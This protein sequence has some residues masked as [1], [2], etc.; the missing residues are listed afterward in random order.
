MGWF[1]PLLGLAGR[2]AATATAGAA[3][4][5]GGAA[6][7]RSG[8]VAAARAN[9]PRLLGSAVAEGAEGAAARRF[10]GDALASLAE[11]RTAALASGR[12]RGAANAPGAFDYIRRAALPQ[13]VGEWGMELAP[14][15]LSAGLTYA[16]LP[17]DAPRL[18]AAAELMGYGVGGSM[19]G[20]LGGGGLAQLRTRGM[21]PRAEQALTDRYS[22]IGG[23]VGGFATA[24]LPLQSLSGWQKEQGDMMQLQQQERDEQIRRQT[25]AGIGAYDMGPYG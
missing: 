11:R 10:A 6:L 18:Q 24:P 1:L 23:M 25:L 21:R 15:L 22:G 8:L 5:A 9:L 13:S 16:T 14:E 20:R 4:E 2:G 17:D 19:L 3:V 12:L 7:A